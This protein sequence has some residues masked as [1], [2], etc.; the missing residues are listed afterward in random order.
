MSRGNVTRK[1]GPGHKGNAHTHTSGLD[2]EVD[3]AFRGV[4]DAVAAEL[5]V[6]AAGGERGEESSET[7][8]YPQQIPGKPEAQASRD[9]LG[10]SMFLE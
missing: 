5:H 3:L 4:R 1:K 8:T 10:L 6:R 2:P 9:L 7:H